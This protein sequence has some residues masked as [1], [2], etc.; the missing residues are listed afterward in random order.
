MHNVHPRNSNPNRRF[1]QHATT[2]LVYRASGA[3]ANQKQDYM[4]NWYLITLIKG[5]KTQN[6]ESLGQLIQAGMNVM[7]MNF[8]HG[9]HEYHQETISNLQSFLNS[10]KSPKTVAVLLDTKGP[11]IRL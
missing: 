6:A 2:I 4:H 8:S 11:E 10:C 9:T 3:C 7:R 1:P 5:P